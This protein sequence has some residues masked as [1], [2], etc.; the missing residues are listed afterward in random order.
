MEGGMLVRR[1][2]QW[3]RWKMTVVWARKAAEGEVTCSQILDIYE[4]QAKTI[5]VGENGIIPRFSGLSN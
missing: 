1:L 4:S 5:N 2:L 3:S